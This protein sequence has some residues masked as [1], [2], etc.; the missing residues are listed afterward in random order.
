MLID[1]GWL[2]PAAETLPPPEQAHQLD[3]WIGEWE[4]S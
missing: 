2:E 1:Q 3:F 4:V